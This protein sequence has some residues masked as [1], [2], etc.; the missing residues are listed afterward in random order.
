MLSSSTLSYGHCLHAFSVFGT[1]SSS[2]ECGLP[3]GAILEVNLYL[4]HLYSYGLIGCHI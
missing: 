3:L 4:T 2:A 1:D